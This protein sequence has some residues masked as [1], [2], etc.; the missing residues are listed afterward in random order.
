MPWKHSLLVALACAAFAFS[1]PLRANDYPNRPI[2]LIVPFPPGGI[3]DTVGRIV[4]QNFDEAARPFFGLDHSLCIWHETCGNVVVVEHNGDFYSCDHFVTPEY[5]LGNI[6]EIPAGNPRVA[7]IRARSRFP[8]ARAML[9][10]TLSG[11]VTHPF[12][13]PRGRPREAS[14]PAGGR[15]RRL[16]RD[17]AH[18]PGA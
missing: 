6:R 2:R 14:D 13:R 15:R 1:A 4:V 3:N 7:S 9:G 16:A 8:L 18:G 10:T 17:A 11:P 12:P 5:R